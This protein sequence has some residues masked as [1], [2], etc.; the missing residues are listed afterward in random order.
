M[1]SSEHNTQYTMH[2]EGT[3]LL[4]C[5][6][7]LFLNSN[8]VYVLIKNIFISR[9]EYNLIYKRIKTLWIFII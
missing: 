8:V 5:S 4:K 3:V 7:I 9:I 1:T 6:C 2:P